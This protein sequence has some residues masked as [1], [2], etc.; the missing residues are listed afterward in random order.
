MFTIFP[1]L[2]ANDTTKPPLQ[3]GMC[4]TEIID[5]ELELHT[6]DLG[7]IKET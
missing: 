3:Y 5:H 1:Y 6:F 2:L 7:V 4:F